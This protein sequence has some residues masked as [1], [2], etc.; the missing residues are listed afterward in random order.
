[1]RDDNVLGGRDVT[2]VREDA[3]AVGRWAVGH[4]DAAVV[5]D[6]RGDQGIMSEL[7][8]GAEQLRA[9]LD[10]GEPRAH[11]IEELVG[12]L[13][14]IRGIAAEGRGDGFAA[15]QPKAIARQEP[16]MLERRLVHA[17]KRTHGVAVRGR[18][19]RLEFPAGNA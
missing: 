2:V 16:K 19:E 5:I 8:S 4:P 13:T 15:D 1:V 7:L 3:Y 17:G 9:A 12:V 14:G 6:P 10:V 11:R 18:G